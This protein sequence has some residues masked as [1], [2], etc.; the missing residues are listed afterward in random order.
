MDFLDIEDAIIID[1]HFNNP[2][3]CQR[4]LLH[5]VNP[6]EDPQIPGLL[7]PDTDL[8]VTGGETPAPPFKSYVLTTF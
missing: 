2:F 5:R 3:R 1:R 4:R 7:N 6:I 8:T